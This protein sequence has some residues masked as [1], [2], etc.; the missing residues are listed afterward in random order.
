LL[1]TSVF[2]SVNKV[3]ERLT[4]VGVFLEKNRYQSLGGICRQKKYTAQDST[5][6]EC[7]LPLI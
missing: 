2:F 1:R 4:L 5:G 3:R 7:V 6:Q